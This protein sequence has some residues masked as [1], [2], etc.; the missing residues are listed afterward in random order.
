MPTSKIVN[1]WANIFTVTKG[2]NNGSFGDRMPGMWFRPGTRRLHICTALGSIPNYCVDDTRDLPA[3]VFTNI[4]IKQKRLSSGSYQ[5]TIRTNGTVRSQL[6]NTSPGILTLY[7][8]KVYFGNPWGSPAEVNV[9]NFV[10]K[11]VPTGNM[12]L[13][14]GQPI[15]MVDSTNLGEKKP[16]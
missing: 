6:I 1:G 13:M 14:K 3:Y 2:G 12:L 9:R 4:N 10:I 8:A 7:N 5:Y 15:D 16:K 11:S